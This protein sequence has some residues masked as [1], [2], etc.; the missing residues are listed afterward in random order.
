M[1]VIHM[2]GEIGI[3]ISFLFFLGLFAGVG[4]AS[5]RVKKDTTD[6]YL[7]AGRGMH[8]ALAALSAVSTWNSGYM[9]IGAV[10]FTYM[11]GYNVLWMAVASMAG[12]LVAWAWLYKFIQQEGR[13]RKVRSLSS[14]VAEK[15]GAPEAK[16]AAILSVLFLSIYAAAQLT[17]GGKALLVML[18]WDEL[19]G[20]LIGFVLVVAYCYAG[21]IRA[22]IW[23]DAVQSCVMIVGS[24]IL[25]W[26]ALGEVGGFSGLNSEL[27]S[28]DPALINIMPPG[29]MFGISMWAFAF[30]LGG[31]AVAGQPQVVSRIMTLDS[32]SDRKQAMVWFFVWQTPFIIMITFIGLASRVLFDSADF[33]PELGLP[34]LA[35][36]TMPALGVGMILASIFAATMSTADSQVLACT[37]AITDDVK[38][39]WR[40]DHKTTKKVTLVVAAFATAISIGGLY[41]PGGDS[42]FKLVVLAVYGLGSVFVPLLIIRWAGFKP[43]STHS[44]VMMV[45]AFS[46]VILW[47]MLPA[48]MGWKTVAGADGIFP[49][50]P[51]MG[52][53]FL[54]HF[55]MCAFRE[56]SDSNSLGRF[57]IPEA[58]K[59]QMIGYGIALLFVAGV[60]EASYAIYAPEDSPSN[61]DKSEIGVYAINGNITYHEIGSGGE[62][63]NDG[64]M[65]TI[66]ASS[67]DGTL[68]GLNIVGFRVISSHVDDEP[69]GN[70]ITCAGVSNEDDLV[71]VS[72][73]IGQ[74]TSSNSGTESPLW[75][76]G[77]F[78]PDILNETLTLSIAEIET[79]LDAGSTG[80][81]EYSFDIEVSTN[82]GSRPG[83]NKQDEGEQVDWTIELISLEYEISEVTE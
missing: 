13:E 58:R 48:I 28:Q 79:L 31:L 10:G 75:T 30:F 41:I 9:F 38:P 56:G 16:L 47:S 32:D 44:I 54:A 83:C 55:L 5:M 66:E 67:D 12:Q 52:A 39:E 17:S 20:I 59:S 61:A 82:A 36:G 15:A 45:S 70:P 43:D 35:M 25:C 7:V 19:I 62:Y 76:Y 68:D 27:K 51:G 14:L 49:S 78:I 80:F 40:E 71:S 3:L 72:G 24:L 34:M 81:G 8:P 21:G 2:S 46:A 65:I 77:L 64:A 1:E 26:I 18:G 73:G 4:L 23:T 69:N 22:S 11:M 60:A 53:A 50:V 37:A 6:D 42:V 57:K 29:L 74:N 63:I 33:D